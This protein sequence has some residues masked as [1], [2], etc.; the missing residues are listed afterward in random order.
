[1]LHYL[2]RACINRR[3][4]S[5][6]GPRGNAVGDQDASSSSSDDASSADDSSSS[7]SSSSDAEDDDDDDDVKEVGETTKRRLK[8]LH[9]TRSRKLFGHPQYRSHF[10]LAG[11]ARLQ[12]SKSLNE[13]QKAE[14]LSELL[15]F[16]AQELR[17]DASVERGDLRGW[18]ISEAVPTNEDNQELLCNMGVLP[19]ILKL[20]HQPVEGHA[21]ERHGCCRLSG[22]GKKRA[23]GQRSI[24]MNTKERMAKRAQRAMCAPCALLATKRAALAFLAQFVRKNRRNQ[25]LVAAEVSVIMQCIADDNK[26]GAALVLKNTFS[27]DDT[28]INARV[29]QHAKMVGSIGKAIHDYGPHARWLHLLG[30][31]CGNLSGSKYHFGGD[32]GA[33]V[34]VCRVCVCKSNM[35]ARLTH[36]IRRSLSTT[37]TTTHT[38]EPQPTSKRQ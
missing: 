13:S 28:R 10:Q 22:A 3:D 25:A 16:S 36:L 7:S 38:S 30:I 29:P 15:S 33:S 1:M 20:L 12:T 26:S 2:R 11:G 18:N 19:L 31:A 8:H 6:H 5:G 4:R 27:G 17:E 32:A 9:S 23:N 21:S 14:D 24:S 34:C 35:T 37:T